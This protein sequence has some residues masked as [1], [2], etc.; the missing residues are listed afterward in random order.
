MLIDTS[1]ATIATASS[2]LSTHAIAASDFNETTHLLNSSVGML[3]HHVPES[4][5]R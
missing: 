1:N 2:A 3:N 5:H 4:L